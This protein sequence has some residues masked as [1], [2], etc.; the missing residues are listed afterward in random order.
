MCDFD[1][2]IGGSAPTSH[3]WMAPLME[4]MLHDARTRLT[5]AVV[6]GPCRAVPFYR[7]HSMGEGLTADKARDTTFLLTGAGM[8]V[9]ILAYLT[10]DPITI[11]E[12]RWAI[13]QAVTD[14]WVKVRGPGHPRVNLPAQ[15]PF[16]FDPP[17]SLPMKDAS[18][19]MVLIINHNPNGPGEAENP[20][21]IGETKG[22]Y[23]LGSPHLPWIMGLRATGVHY[24]WLPWCCLG[25]PG[26]TDPDVPDEGDVTDRMELSWR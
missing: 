13:A 25:L 15:Q 1:R 5:E 6:I 21:D 18:E 3:S 7:R 16:R 9:G 8:W 22:L 20:I 2:R 17:K 4:D 19:V 26:Q 14:H 12:G 11:Q 10:A 24:Q 23:H